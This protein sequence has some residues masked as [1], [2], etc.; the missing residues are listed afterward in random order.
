MNFR[1]ETLQASGASSDG[2]HLLCVGRHEVLSA[3][4]PARPAQTCPQTT[5]P[6]RWPARVLLGAG[7]DGVQ[8]RC[9]CCRVA[10]RLKQEGSRA[11]RLQS[12]LPRRTRSLRSSKPSAFSFQMKSSSPR[13]G[14]WSLDRLLRT[15]LR[16]GERPMSNFRLQRSSRSRAQYQRSRAALRV[17][18]ALD[19]AASGRTHAESGAPAHS[20]RSASGGWNC[21]TDPPD[22]AACGGA[23]GRAT[24][25]RPKR[26]RGSTPSAGRCSRDVVVGGRR[27]GSCRASSSTSL[28]G[29]G[30]GSVRL[31][32]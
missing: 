17:M 4:A 14:R 29:R 31:E 9:P 12:T 7:H 26:P 28:Q 10:P 19:G 20:E 24:A 1:A 23:S 32:P 25:P 21:C 11:G 5:Q 6:R 16:V 3:R 8:E 22:R 2:E 27:C 18:A 13:P 15:Q 30:S